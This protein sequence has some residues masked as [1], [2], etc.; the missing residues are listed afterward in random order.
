MTCSPQRWLANHRNLVA[1]A[2]LTP[3]HVKPVSNAVLEVLR[4]RSGTATLKITG[5]YTGANEATYDFEILDG[6]AETKLISA[7]VYTGVGSETLEDIAADGSVDAQDFKVECHSAGQPAV[8]A[9]VEVQGVSIKARTE[10]VAGNGIHIHVD[11]SGLTFTPSSFSLIEDVAKG[12]GGE[13]SPM[14]GPQFDWDTAAL[15]ADGVVPL[16]AHRF[17]FEGDTSNVYVQYKQFVDNEWKYFTVPALQ[18]DYAAGTRVLFVDGTYTVTII[19]DSPP[20]T[21]TLIDIVTLYDFLNLVKT[22]S[23]LADVDGV[24]ANDRT[25]TGQ[26]TLDFPLRTQA[27]ALLSTGEGSKAA[28]GFTDVTVEP[29]ANT[30]LVTAECIAIDFK[31]D[32]HAWVGHEAWQLKGSVSG[33]LGI[34]YT[35]EPFEGDTFSLTIPKKLPPTTDN[36]AATFT[37]TDFTRADADAP[38]VKICFAGKLGPNATDQTI[39]LVYTQRPSTACECDDMPVPELNTR[40]LGGEGAEGTNMGYSAEAQTRINGLYDWVSELAGKCSRYITGKAFDGIPD[41]S[42]D[43]GAVEQDVTFTVPTVSGMTQGGTTTQSGGTFDIPLD[44]GAVDTGYADVA[45]P[46]SFTTLI[47]SFDQTLQTID[48][49]TDNTLQTAGFAAWDAAVDAIQAD[50]VESALAAMGY[51]LA[52]VANGKYQFMLRRALAAAGVS[53]L[54]K[55]NA[56]NVSGDG[57]WQDFGDALYWKVV[58]ANGEYAPAFTNHPY[59]SS[60]KNADGVYFSTKEFAFILNVK[61]PED[62]RVGDTI[63]LTIGNA[64]GLGTYQVGDV[65]RLPIIAAADAYLAGGVD[66]DNE[67]SWYVTGSVQGAF[68][69][70]VFDPDTPTAYNANG[71]AMQLVMGGVLPAAGDTF[72]FS[73]IGAHYRW[74]KD[75]GPWVGESPPSPVPSGPVAFDSGLSL[76]FIPGVKPA[77][78]EDDAWTF[79]AL[80]QWTAE[81]LKL[82]N[83]APWFP[84]NATAS[85]EVVFEDGVKQIDAIAIALHTIPEGAMIQV[86]GGDA[87]GVTDW[88]ETLTWQANTIVKLVDRTA[89][90]ARLELSGSGVEDAVVGWFYVGP[91]DSTALAGDVESLRN[92]YRIERPQVGGLSQGGIFLGKTRSAL[93]TFS[94]GALDEAGAT[95]LRTLLDHVK[96]N[97]DEAFI[98]LPQATRPDEALLCQ[99]VEDQIDVR[100]VWKYQPD[101]VHD[102]RYSAQLTLQGVWNS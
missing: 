98:F 4:A 53:P 14:V 30:E 33:E 1:T 99:V 17:A 77:F 23:T 43:V 88:T 5:E 8:A 73:V 79:R 86:V 56:S 66:V 44:G 47:D 76:E 58:G 80:Q 71:L 21:D 22:T 87:I 52:S 9:A 35:D 3:S 57:C 54:G 59:W 28:K 64:A 41:A 83:R 89:S 11:V 42:A 65:L 94:E 40:C 96:T 26:A 90:W 93:V 34:I 10:G 29:D 50:L 60:R 39:T 24:V 2:E 13:G 19:Q 6:D 12:D 31:L 92:D 81:N 84:G 82:P 70:Y 62:L 97:N 36:G 27:R 74:R 61:C 37:L 72:L 67:Q 55:S 69:P 48:A 63:T 75:G 20:V 18:N 15:G 49:V 91:A 68:P 38:E 85:C 46:V 95:M 45:L 51:R 25:P 16:T 100:D 102:R 78:V 32:P 101:V 7:P